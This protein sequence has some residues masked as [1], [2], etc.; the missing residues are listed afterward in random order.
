MSMSNE[1][2]LKA[3]EDMIAAVS[4][5]RWY[6][7]LQAPLVVAA[8]FLVPFLTLWGFGV[9]PSVAARIAVVPSALYT[10]GEITLLS[11]AL[12]TMAVVLDKVTVEKSVEVR[13]DG[14]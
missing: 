10:A 5:V 3:A 2:T 14:W 4:K 8:W 13:K 6:G 1:R 12:A 9:E 11:L 7:V